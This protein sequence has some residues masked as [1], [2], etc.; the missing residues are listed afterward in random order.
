MKKI[1]VNILLLSILLSLSFSCSNDSE[2]SADP[3]NTLDI[4]DSIVQQVSQEDLLRGKVIY[5]NK[6]QTCHQEDGMGVEGAF[7][8]LDSL[9]TEIHIVIN[10]VEGSTMIAFKDEL[11]NEELVDVINYVNNSWGKSFG[12]TTI[13][14]IEELE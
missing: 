4:N 13:K 5:T 12:K 2:E 10:G 6:C 14:D 7:P 11:T 9:K 1:S 8:A 3:M